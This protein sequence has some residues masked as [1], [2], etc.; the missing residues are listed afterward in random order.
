MPDKKR[1]PVRVWAAIMVMGL[2]VTVWSGPQNVKSSPAA[3][4]PSGLV[5]VIVSAN[6]EWKAVRTEFP[7]E[8]YEKSPYGEYFLKNIKTRDGREHPVLVFFGGWG[9]VP[10]AASAQYV[11]D[12]WKPAAIFNLGTCGGFQG[13]IERGT[14]VLAERTIIY[15]IIERM[16]DADATIEEM[17]TTLD[18][19]WL[20]G[21]LPAGV[22]RGLLVSGDQDL[23]PAAV[24]RLRKKYGAAAGDW[25]SGAIAFIAAKNG[26]RLLILRGVTDLVHPAGGEAYGNI[27]LFERNSR[28]IMKRLFADLPFWLEQ[29]DRP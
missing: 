13:A 21:P 6:G 25:E 16:G 27:E 10:A 9:K 7:G 12:R 5:A 28:A 15:D 11:I 1:S 22:V 8:R 20:K 19:S 26:T 24:P 14:I 18:L 17:S 4:S 3:P 23:D 29:A 2:A